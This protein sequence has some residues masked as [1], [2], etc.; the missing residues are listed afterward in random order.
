MNLTL[1]G[2]MVSL[3][4]A[5]VMIAIGF[6]KKKNQILWLQCVQFGIM[7]FG[8]LLLGG[9]TGV[10]SNGVCIVRNLLSLKV[11]FTMP[12]KLLFIGIQGVLSL[13]FNQ[14]GLV[15]WLPFAAA[16]V[17]TFCLDTRNET[18]LKVVIIVGQA[19]WGIYD[20]SMSNYTAMVFDILAIL[21]NGISIYSMKTGKYIS[22]RS[23]R[24][25]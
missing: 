4:G 23:F 13:Q 6:V 22:W 16:C 19:F 15:G 17:F 11:P 18:V 8:N 21:T 9:I 20:A 5:F 14:A 3:I 1:L 12:W 7:G 2:N 25:R 10:I 24:R